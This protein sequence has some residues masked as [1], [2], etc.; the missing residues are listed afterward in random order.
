MTLYKF[1][2]I[3]RQQAPAVHWDILDLEPF[4]P[5]RTPEHQCPVQFVADL[6]GLIADAGIVSS[7][8]QLGIVGASA[9]II[10]AADGNPAH[11]EPLI[12]WALLRAVKGKKL[13]WFDDLRLRFKSIRLG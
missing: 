7:L 10:H 4:R 11:P 9:A 12:R 8:R 5:L 3:F 2:T 1:L 6:R 13:P